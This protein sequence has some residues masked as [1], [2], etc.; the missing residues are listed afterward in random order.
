MEQGRMDEAHELGAGAEH[1]R[2]DH[3]RRGKYVKR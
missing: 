3:D 2:H 1:A